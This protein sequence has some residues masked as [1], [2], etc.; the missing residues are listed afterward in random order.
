MRHESIPESLDSILQ[1]FKSCFTKPSFGNFAHLVSGWIVCRGR[2]WITRVL[3]VGGVLGRTHHSRFYR[4]F[5]AAR[6]SP[7]KLGHCLFRL[8]LPYLPGII[9]AM[10]DDTLCRRPGPR[11][12]GISMH[13]DGVASSYG[14]GVLACGHS[15]VVLAVRVPLVG[16]GKS[17]GWR[18]GKSGASGTPPTTPPSVKCEGA[19]RWRGQCRSSGSCAGS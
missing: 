7:D 14:H 18:S 4:F 8:L 15:W 11:I 3:S 19:G 16:S 13:H 2:R 6:W 12:F 1:E 5:S 17:D 9:E 10:V